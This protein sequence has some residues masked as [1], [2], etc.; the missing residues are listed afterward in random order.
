MV[1]FGENESYKFD[2]DTFLRTVFH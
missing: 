1:Q 2:K